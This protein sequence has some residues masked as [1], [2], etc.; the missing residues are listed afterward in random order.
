MRYKSISDRY[1][2]LAGTCSFLAYMYRKSIFS[3]KILNIKDF[4]FQILISYTKEFYFFS[5][6]YKSCKQFF[7]GNDLRPMG[8][9]F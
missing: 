3:T 8:K 5:K 9:E 6:F 7:P 1:L 2:N 4:F